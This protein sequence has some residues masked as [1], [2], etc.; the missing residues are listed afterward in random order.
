MKEGWKPR[1]LNFQLMKEGWKPRERNFQLMKEGWKPRERN[2]QLMKEGWK[3]RERIDFVNLN[4]TVDQ[5]LDQFSKVQV[6]KIYR[7]CQL[8]LYGGPIFGPIQ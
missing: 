7:F 4:F 6:D 2:F 3:P 1:E 5:F 8:E